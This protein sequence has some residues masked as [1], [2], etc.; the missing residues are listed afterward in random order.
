MCPRQG[1]LSCEPPKESHGLPAPGSAGPTRAARTES[2]VSYLS[3]TPFSL[4]SE[5]EGK[6]ERIIVLLFFNLIYQAT[7]SGHLYA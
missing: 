2:H 3:E 4:R 6:E 7:R 1:P 5:R